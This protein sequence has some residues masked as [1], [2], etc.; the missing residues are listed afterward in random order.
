M[1]GELDVLLLYITKSSFGLREDTTAMSSV[2]L[3]GPIL[4]FII[5]TDS[6]SLRAESITFHPVKY[7]LS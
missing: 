2:T 1:S 6:F 4:K 7:I 5:F 3:P